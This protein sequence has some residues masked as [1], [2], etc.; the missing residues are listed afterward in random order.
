VQRKE[1]ILLYTLQLAKQKTV[2][3]IKVIENGNGNNGKTN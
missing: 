3:E 2:K 1:L